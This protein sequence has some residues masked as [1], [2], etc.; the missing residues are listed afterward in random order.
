MHAALAGTLILDG[1]YAEARAAL[2]KALTLVPADAAPANIRYQV[3]FTHLY[4][5]TPLREDYARETLAS[6][7]KLWTR[8]VHIRTVLEDKPVLW[9]H[10]GKETKTRDL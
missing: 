2:E 9:S 8:P 10:D 5:G 6:L 7:Q 3:A 4:E 1:E